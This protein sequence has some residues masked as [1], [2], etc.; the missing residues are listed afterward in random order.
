[1]VGPPERSSTLGFEDARHLVEEH[2]AK[3]SPGSIDLVDLW[4]GNGRV[5]AEPIS[6]ARAFPPFRRVARDG[7]AV[8]AADVQ[9][10]PATLDVIGEIKAGATLDQI[11]TLRPGQAAAIMTGAPAPAGAD[12]VVMVEYTSRWGER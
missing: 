6:A 5:L 12:A 4:N 10:L 7:Y 1:M 2:A 9:E 11:P 8:R 3:L